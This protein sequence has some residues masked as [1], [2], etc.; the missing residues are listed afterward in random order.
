MDGE[1]GPRGRGNRGAHTERSSSV[2][3]EEIRSEEDDER[4]TTV[5]TS[6]S[7]YHNRHYSGKGDRERDSAPRRQEQQRGGSAPPAD[8]PVT[9]DASP[10]PERPVEKK[11]YSLARRTR[12]RATELDKQASLEEPASTVSSSALTSEPW[13]GPSQSQGDAGDSSQA[14]VLTGLDQDLARLSLAGQ[15]WAQNPTSFLRAEMRGEPSLFCP[16][17]T[18]FYLSLALPL[19]LKLLLLFE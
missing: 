13:Q 18:P 9:R 16:R 6:Q 11:S 3:V 8:N 15:N 2:V 19:F 4:N 7:V 1:R 14:T 5:T 12:T 17:S 10:A